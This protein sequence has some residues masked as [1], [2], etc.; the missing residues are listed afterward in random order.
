MHSLSKIGSTL[1]IPLKADKY[2]KDKSMLRYARLLVEMQLEGQFSEYIKFANEKNVPI[3]Q[4]VVSSREHNQ[5]PIGNDQ[6][7]QNGK[8][9]FQ[10]ATKYV[11]KQQSSRPFE[12]GPSATTTGLV[13]FLETKVQAHNIANVIEKI[14]L[15]WEWLHNATDIERGRIIVS[16]HLRRYQFSL[17][18]M[19]DH[20]IHGKAF[21]LSTNKWF[22]I[23][24][25]Y[26]RNVEDQRLPLWNSLKDI[27]Q[28]LNGPWSV[29][30]DFNSVLHQGERPGGIEVTDGEMRS[31]VDCIQQCNLQEFCYEG[32]FFTW[33][34]KTIWSRIDRAL[35]NELWYDAFVYTHVHYKSQGLSDHTLIIINF[36]HLP[37]PKPTFL[38]YD[39]WTK[40]RGFKGLA[41]HYLAQPHADTPRK[42]L[43]QVLC[44]LRKPLQPA[45]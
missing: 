10:T 35:H 17:L 41:R 26:G 40:D 24:F 14:C 31:F 20:V 29:I 1:G 7:E 6:N 19:N 27:S 9:S 36:P 45:E 5:Q 21:Q 39:M 43:Q 11:A 16:W 2:T 25:V 18:H 32:A 12:P 13:R 33:T 37:K 23:R 22:E 34:N 4:K 38:F 30:G 44:R 15:N 42:Q 28:S 3:R 8:E